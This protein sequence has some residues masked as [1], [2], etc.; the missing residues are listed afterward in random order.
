[1]NKVI[2]DTNILVSALWLKN[3]NPNK[4]IGLIPEKII[5]P[6]FCQEILKEYRKV[7]RR[8]KFDF[9]PLEV[10]KLL[11]ELLLY[12]VEVDPVKSD[13]PF[14]EEGDRIFYD[15][16]RV[17]GAVLITGNIKH[18]P[19]ETFIMAPNDFLVKNF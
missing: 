16:A 1:M 14:V 2:I 11:R 3:G 8:P 10:N 4:I 9:S 13:I 6:Y 7:L 18:Y 5:I 15:A 17:S 19:S 12:G